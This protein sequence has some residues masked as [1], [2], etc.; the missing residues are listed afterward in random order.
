MSVCV[1]VSTYAVQYGS[2]Q[3]HEVIELLKRGETEELNFFVLLNFNLNS[4][5]WLVS[6]MSDRTTIE[7]FELNKLVSVSYYQ[8]SFFF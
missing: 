7:F 1:C 5:L 6:K 4:H 8:Q 3:P 2:H